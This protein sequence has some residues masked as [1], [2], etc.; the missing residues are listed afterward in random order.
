MA[1]NLSPRGTNNIKTGHGLPGGL[2]K[3]SSPLN[4]AKKKVD[5]AF[6]PALKDAYKPNSVLRVPSMTNEG[7]I[8]IIPQF[9]TTKKP[10]TS[11]INKAGTKE[12]IEADKRLV[13]W[14][15]HPETLK[16]FEKNTGF[17]KRRLTDMVAKGL[18][19]PTFADTKHDFVP[20]GAEAVYFSPNMSTEHIL[21]KNTSTK[22]GHIQ[23]IPQGK[24]I[25]FGSGV[26]YAADV[27]GTLQHERAHAMKAD[28][29]LAPALYRALGQKLPKEYG[30]K[31]SYMNRPEEVYANF[32]N[33]R[34]DMGYKPGQKTTVEEF[35]KKYSGNKR[36]Q[37]N[38]FFQKFGTDKSGQQSDKEIAKIVNAINTVAI[39]GDKKENKLQFSGDKNSSY[40]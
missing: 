6:R 10:L 1:F 31:L 18:Q 7:D 22:K 20:E 23:Y 9:D 2:I 36:V 33:L 24:D 3:P 14:Y 13:N 5:A 37:G 8:E 30:S 38:R 16:K 12:E 34:V 29:V 15:S 11:L 39:T 35:K 32:H 21:P 28:A 4:Q 40:A 17:D 26:Q 27:H 25:N 19:V